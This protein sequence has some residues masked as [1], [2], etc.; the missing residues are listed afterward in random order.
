MYWGKDDPRN[1]V[2][3]DYCR[4]SADTDLDGE[5]DRL[6]VINSQNDPTDFQGVMLKS[7][8]KALEQV[9][10]YLFIVVFYS[11]IIFDILF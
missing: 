9:G 2:R 11:L 3:L 6:Q 1:T 7:I 5:I 10:D 4:L 8:V